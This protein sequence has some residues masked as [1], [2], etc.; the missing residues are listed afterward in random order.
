MPSFLLD[1]RAW[2]LLLAVITTTLA[3]NKLNNTGD[4]T[5]PTNVSLPYLAQSF[6]RETGEKL[7]ALRIVAF[8][9][10]WPSSRSSANRNQ[11]PAGLKLPSKDFIDA[12]KRAKLPVLVS[13][14]R[15]SVEMVIIRP[16]E[17]D[18]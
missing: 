14:L 4:Y 3:Q 2:Y 5:A 11:T 15:C 16:I 7:K 6:W 12:I 1:K 17:L 10:G 9:R 8:V 18:V 13:M